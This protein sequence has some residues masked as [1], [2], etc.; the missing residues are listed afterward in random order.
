MNLKMLSSL[1]P[2]TNSPIL[3]QIDPKVED[4]KHEEKKAD[5]Y[6]ESVAHFHLHICKNTARKVRA[7]IIN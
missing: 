1:L 3:V 2:E 4:N 7:V 6:D 5:E